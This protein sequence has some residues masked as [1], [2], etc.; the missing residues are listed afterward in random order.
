M[1]PEYA[2][3]S[4]LRLY[5]LTRRLWYQH[6]NRIICMERYCLVTVE[7]NFTRWM[8]T[9]GR[10]FYVGQ[11]RLL[12]RQS[13]SN[14]LVYGVRWVLEIIARP[15]LK[16][17]CS[18]LEEVEG[19][20]GCLLSLSHSLAIVRWF[21]ELNEWSQASSIPSLPWSHPGEHLR[22]WYLDTVGWCSTT[23]AKWAKRVPKHKWQTPHNWCAPW[24]SR[25]FGHSA[26]IILKWSESGDY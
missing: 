19:G 6:L 2:R 9:Y 3:S 5:L 21:H 4:G 10:M 18:N 22:R 25:Q 16:L 7:I 20:Q 17:F 23:N 12:Y 8:D 24:L 26:S 1:W 14:S 11:R 13:S 15:M